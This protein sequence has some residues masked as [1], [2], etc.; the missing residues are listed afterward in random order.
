MPHPNTTA[1][2]VSAES[3]E[4]YRRRWVRA[5][6]AVNVLLLLLGTGFFTAYYRAWIHPDSAQPVWNGP[7]T[8]GQRQTVFDALWQ[9]VDQRYSYLA[10]KGIDWQAR[11]EVYWPQAQAAPDD[12]AFYAVLERML[13]SLQDG[14]TDL[15]NYPGEPVQTAPPVIIGWVEEQPVVTTVGQSLAG[16]IHPGDVLTAVDGNPAAAM[17]ATL[18]PYTAASTEASL[19]LRVAGALLRGPAGSRLSATFRTPDGGTYT[20]DLERP[21]PGQSGPSTAQTMIRAQEVEGFGYIRILGWQGDAATAF[22]SALAQFKTSPGLII[23]VRGNGGGNDVLAEQVAGRLLTTETPFTRIRLR[24][25]P[26][27]TPAFTRIVQPRGPWQYT[28]P[29]ALLID[30]R[31]F[32]SN[33]FFVGGLARG[34]K[35][36]TFGAPTGGGSG[37]PALITL[38]G[39]ARVRIS[40]WIET[41]SDG[42]PVEGNGTR[43]D[44]RV[45][46]SIGDIASGLDP[47]LETAVAL[48]RSRQR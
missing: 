21:L 20:L 13:A 1:E 2:R 18:R 11:R 33:D 46:P 19:N 22:D 6:L 40:R 42:T 4:W 25:Y 43:P 32:S 29:V 7:L 16:R 8:A 35:V 44:I 28:G 47:V 34:G 3:A 48:L 14:H 26:F 5:T 36:T 17:A 24:V 45:E 37:N 27:W 31:V 38:P 12:R 9:E 39:G 23:D 10:L 30:G 41:F 15:V